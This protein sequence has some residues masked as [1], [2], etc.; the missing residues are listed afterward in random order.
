MCKMAYTYLRSL[1]DAPAS[2]VIVFIVVWASDRYSAPHLNVQLARF[3]WTRTC[4]A[5]DQY[6]ISYHTTLLRAGLHGYSFKT[7]TTCSRLGA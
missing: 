5:M 2:T 1:E 4:T 7:R 3:A 6:R